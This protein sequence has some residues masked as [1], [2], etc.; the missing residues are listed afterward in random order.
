MS[1]PT[2]LKRL[3]CSSDFLCNE[4]IDGRRQTTTPKRLSDSVTSTIDQA[5]KDCNKLMKVEEQ[6]LNEEEEEDVK[7]ILGEAMM[8]WW[9]HKRSKQILAVGVGQHDRSFLW[10]VLKDPQVSIAASPPLHHN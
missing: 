5:D 6:Q 10:Q 4:T 2:M 1:Q 9:E 7:E 3:E 8:W